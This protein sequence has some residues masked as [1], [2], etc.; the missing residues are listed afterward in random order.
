MAE[1]SKP[2]CECHLDKYS[3]DMA[4]YCDGYGSISASGIHKYIIIFVQFTVIDIHAQWF[5]TNI[6]K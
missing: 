4:R 2:A 6:F 5:I 3:M 1:W